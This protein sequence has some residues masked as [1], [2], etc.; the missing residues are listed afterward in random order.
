MSWEDVGVVD[1]VIRDHG[2]WGGSTRRP[3]TGGACAE[4]VH[5]IASRPKP[6]PRSPQPPQPGDPRN[7]NPPTPGTLGGG[8]APGGN[9]SPWTS[10]G[11]YAKCVLALI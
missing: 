1:D 8:I 9:L 6:G 7:R 3:P 10:K 4:L 2:D 11:P 5:G